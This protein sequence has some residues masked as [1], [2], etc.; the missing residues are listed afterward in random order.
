MGKHLRSAVLSR[1]A[2]HLLAPRGVLFEG[3]AYEWR[4]SA[5]RFLRPTGVSSSGPL[6]AARTA[7]QGDENWPGEKLR[8]ETT[9][10]DKP[11]EVT[12]RR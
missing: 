11:S 9:W 3:E 4:P 5:H 10:L 6:P 7:V 2:W 1:M 12:Q 8:F